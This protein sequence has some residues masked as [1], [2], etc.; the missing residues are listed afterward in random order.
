MG[1]YHFLAGSEHSI[2]DKKRLSVPTQYRAGLGD[3][4]F[5]CKSLNDKCLWLMPEEEFNSLLDRMKEKIPKVDK[6]G[7]RWIGLFTE[8][9]TDRQLDKFNRI[10]IPSKLLEYANIDNR[11]KLIGHD[12]RIEIWALEVWQEEMEQGED[13]NELTEHMFEKYEI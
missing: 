11:V 13:F 1:N 6:K 4:F 9:A 5:L 10:T 3:K 12:E 2:D 8:G 7:Q